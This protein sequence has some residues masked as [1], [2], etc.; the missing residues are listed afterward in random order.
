MGAEC[1]RLCNDIELDAGGACQT[2]K[3][4][5]ARI[6]QRCQDQW[7]VKNLR[8]AQQTTVPEADLVP[9]VQRLLEAV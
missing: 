6:G 5:A 9:H 1:L 4:L 7:Q 2:L 8:A 3:L